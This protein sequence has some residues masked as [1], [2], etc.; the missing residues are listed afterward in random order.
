MCIFRMLF[1]VSCAPVNKIKSTALNVLP[2][3][4]TSAHNLEICIF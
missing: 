3:P 4:L 1:S 2:F